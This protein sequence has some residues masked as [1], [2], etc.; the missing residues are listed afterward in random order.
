MTGRAVRPGQEAVPQAGLSADEKRLRPYQE[1]L[2]SAYA[3]CMDSHQPWP[4]MRL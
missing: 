1:T 4:G 2:A 3:L